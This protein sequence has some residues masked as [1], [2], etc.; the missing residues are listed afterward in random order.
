MIVVITLALNAT[1]GLST[2]AYCLVSEIKPEQVLL[3]A[4]ISIITGVIGWIGGML[5]KSSPTSTTMM[6]TVPTMPP[7]G[8]PTEVK[9]VNQPKDPVPTEESN[10]NLATE[11]V[12]P[13]ISQSTQLRPTTPL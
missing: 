7:N 8:A 12:K 3:T 1:I 6:A 9:V 5:V 11:P 13:R 10:K 4:F 2:L